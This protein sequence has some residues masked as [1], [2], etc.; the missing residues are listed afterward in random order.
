MNDPIVDEVRRV[1][2]AHAARFDYDLDAIY[3]DLKEQEKKSG[4]NFV[5]FSSSRAEP[6]Q[7]I[8]PTGAGMPRT[9]LLDDRRK[10]SGNDDT[11]SVRTPQDRDHR[12]RSSFYS[13]PAC[14]NDLAFT[15]SLFQFLGFR[16]LPVTRLRARMNVCRPRIPGL[17]AFFQS[18]FRAQ[19]SWD[20]RRSAGVEKL[21]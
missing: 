6:C 13:S 18:T 8:E 7:A 14:C 10:G 17:V 16:I 9:L 2:D 5:S 15:E 4:R 19:A 12:S 11:E 20:T 1:R 21:S 3:Q